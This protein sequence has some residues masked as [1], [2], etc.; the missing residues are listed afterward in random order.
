MHTK[1]TEMAKSILSDICYATLATATKTGIPWCSPVYVAFDSD[2]HFYWL[3]P[4]QARH[5]QNIGENS[6]VAFVVYN[7][8]APER[9]GKGV[10][11]QATA[12]ELTD[13][14]EIAYG[15]QRI[16]E[17]AGDNPP[18]VSD[19]TGNSP[20]RVYKAESHAMWINV[21]DSIDGKHVDKRVAIDLS[22]K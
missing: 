19:V 16:F 3:S 15:L 4:L 9:T 12:Y 18:P 21:G 17:R 20:L 13:K 2:F 22:N 7:S 1:H 14:D 10:Y 8:T 5:S 11:I 6:Q